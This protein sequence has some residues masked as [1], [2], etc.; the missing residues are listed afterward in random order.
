MLSFLFYFIFLNKWI[1]S[2]FGGVDS[3][4]SEMEL[5]PPFDILSV[6]SSR[7]VLLCLT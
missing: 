7:L 3:I 1:L 6:E 5:A 4:R 2:S